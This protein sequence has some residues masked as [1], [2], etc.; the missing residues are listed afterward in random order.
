[1]NHEDHINLLHDY[2]R[3]RLSEAERLE[4]EQSLSA[5]ANLRAELE[6]VKK[7]YG[8]LKTLPEINASDDFFLKVRA[9]IDRPSLSSRFKRMFLYPLHIKLPLE[10]AATVGLSLFVVVI[11]NP[12][13]PKI[14]VQEKIAMGVKSDTVYEVKDITAFENNELTKEEDVATRAKKVERIAPVATAKPALAGTSPSQQRQVSPKTAAM[15]ARALSA[16]VP[17]ASGLQKRAF[18]DEQ[19]AAGESAPAGA[20]EE[21][22]ELQSL[23][24][25]TSVQAEPGAIAEIAYNEKTETQPVYGEA[26]L[27]SE[28]LIAYTWTPSRVDEPRDMPQESKR[29]VEYAQFEKKSAKSKASA[30]ASAGGLEE[31]KALDNN[32]YVKDMKSNDINYIVNNANRL[33]GT[34]TPEANGSPKYRVKI[35][36]K[37]YREFE[38][39]LKSRGVLASKTPLNPARFSSGGSVEFVISIIEK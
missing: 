2:V 15:P 11:F 25:R 26:E 7:Y 1:M 6:R 20:P 4:V 33:G 18:A 22:N 14:P 21:D 5:D 39:A 28:P 32:S 30:P 19:Y 38:N 3:G 12:F 8:E 23:P 24:A 13:A 37:N 27:G 34:C 9:R 31:S 16:T 29:E 36:V 10:V 17:S 35:P